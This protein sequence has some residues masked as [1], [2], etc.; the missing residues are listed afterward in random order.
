MKLIAFE[1]Q[2]EMKFGAVDVRG[3]RAIDCQ[4]VRALR[5]ARMPAPASLMELID[6]GEGGLMQVRDDLSWA[7]S[8][9]TNAEAGIHNLSSVKLLP[10]TG[11]PPRLVCFS[12]YA[13]HMRNAAKAVMTMRLGIIGRGIAATGLVPVPNKG[14]YRSAIY[15]KGN[16]QSVSGPD[17]VILWPGQSKMLDYEM[18]LGVVMGRGGLNIDARDAMSHVFGYTVFNDFSARDW[19]MKEILQMRGPLKSKDFATGNAL[20]PWVVTRDEVVD[21]HALDMKVRVNGVQQAQS[22][23]SQMSH[24][25]DALIAEASRHEPLPAGS[26]IGTGCAT[27]GCGLEQLKFLKPGDLVEIEIESVGTLRNRIANGQHC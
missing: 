12:V 6:Q 7:E 16:P 11:I 5:E 22:N 27:N 26:V 13:G 14:F 15:Y 2:G 25:I 4:R 8:H 1:T 24:R 19:L 10:P 23:T 20:G 3:Q 17:Q 21:P 9:D 18:E